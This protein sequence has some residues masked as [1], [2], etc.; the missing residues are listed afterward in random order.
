MN[1]NDKVELES[2][3]ATKYAATMAEADAKAISKEAGDTMLRIMSKNKIT[4]Y[5][6]PGFGE[7]KVLISKGSAILSDRLTENLLIEG[8]DPDK[9]EEI[10]DKSSS[11]WEKPYATLVKEK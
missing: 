10:I 6:L 9:I 2:A 7:A 11:K 8:M 4:I 5:G 1:K 3:I